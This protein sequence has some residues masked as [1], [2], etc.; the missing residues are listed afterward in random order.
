MRGARALVILPK[1]ESGTLVS[2]LFNC[3]WLNALKNSPRSCNLTFSRR[4][5]TLCA[6]KSTFTVP[7]P[8]RVFRPTL[9]NVLSAGMPKHWVWNQLLMRWPRFPLVYCGVQS[10]CAWSLPT[11]GRLNEVSLPDVMF[12]GKPLCMVQ[13]P[14]VS[15]PPKAARI[16]PDFGDGSCHR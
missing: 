16:Q 15:H 6:P 9:P 11:A 5:N 2:G 3:V 8:I 13:I 4:V 10:C 7:G 12:S 14:D 1:V